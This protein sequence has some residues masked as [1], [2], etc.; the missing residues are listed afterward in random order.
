M[1]AKDHFEPARPFAVDPVSGL[2]CISK[3]IE[4][5]DSVSS[6]SRAVYNAIRKVKANVGGEVRF[7]EGYSYPFHYPYPGA[8]PVEAEIVLNQLLNP[9]SPMQRSPA[10]FLNLA[11]RAELLQ[12]LGIIL[13][14]DP[15]V[16]K[17]SPGAESG[18]QDIE[19]G[20]TLYRICRSIMP[21][22]SELYLIRS[23][24][25]CRQRGITISEELA[26]ATTLETLINNLPAKLGTKGLQRLR[27]VIQQPSLVKCAADWVRGCLKTPLKRAH[28]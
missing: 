28:T 2:P 14:P 12:S 8:S 17:V 26:V 3:R 25:D 4:I 11:Y 7:I 9:S 22:A 20:G 5:A 6:T 13:P 21:S 24:H 23:V 15:R 19:A 27:P 16:L 1:S 10:E 18:W